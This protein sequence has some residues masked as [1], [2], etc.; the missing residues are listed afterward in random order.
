MERN[1]L[2]WL[3]E[4]PAAERDAAIEMAL[5]IDSAPAQKPLGKDRMGYM[6][7]GIAPI[8]RT[9]LDVPIGPNDVFVDLGSGLGKVT[10]AVH[11]L[12]G[13]RA[14]GVELQPDLVSRARAEASYLGLQGVSFVEA[15]ALNADLDDATVL[16]LYLPFTGDVLAGVM[17]GSRPSRGE[18][19]SSSAR[20]GSTSEASTGSWN[21]RRRSSGCR[22]TTPASPAPRLARRRRPCRSR[23]SVRSSPANGSETERGESRPLVTRITSDRSARR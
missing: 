9:V 23:P 20:W 19:T 1:L 17:G 10:M 4:H 7:A 2:G 15:D 6:P 11:L 3:E 5:G 12:T 8:V 16:F 22:S 18:G 21:V 14:I 13:A